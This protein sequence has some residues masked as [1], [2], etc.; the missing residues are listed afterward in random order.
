MSKPQDLPLGHIASFVGGLAVATFGALLVAIVWGQYSTEPTQAQPAG[1]SSSI[2][3]PVTP[4]RTQPVDLA[5]N[6]TG[7]VSSSAPRNT[8][9]GTVASVSDGDTLV[10]AEGDRQYV[11]R[12]QGID[13]PEG[14]QP[15]GFVAT[16]ALTLKVGQ[17]PVQVKW[18]EH[19]KYNRVLGHIYVGER[20]INREMVADGYAW[21]YKEYS[22]D[23]DLAAAEVAARVKRLGLWQDEHAIPPWDYRHSP[24]LAVETTEAAAPRPSTIAPAKSASPESEEIM[25]YV[26]RTGSKYHRAGCRHLSKSRIPISLSEAQG[27]YGRCSVCN[28]P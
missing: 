2:S 3:Q 20:Y 27:R 28:P 4:S 11:I 8:I 17:S 1:A 23:A 12:L 24:P 22:T 9:N 10:V 26:T 18:T 13:A 16:Q 21:H 14:S 25:V 6:A 5:P 15:F 7:R 19:D